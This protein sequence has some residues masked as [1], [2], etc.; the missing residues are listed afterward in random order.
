MKFV[1]IY[2]IQRFDGQPTRHG[3]APKKIF[4]SK[5]IPTGL[6]PRLKYWRDVPSRAEMSKRIG[7][8]FED[9]FKFYPNEEKLN[10]AVNIVQEKWISHYGTSL[11]VT[12][13][14]ESF[15]TLPKSTSAGLPF[16]SGCTKYEARN[17]MMRFARSQ[18]DRV[19]KELQ[20][21]VLPCRLGARCQLRKRGENKPRL[22][23]AYPG[24]LSIIEN[25]YLT[26]IKKVPPP[27]FIGWST[28]WLDGGKSLN[29]LLFGDKWTWQ[30]IAQIDF[31]SFDATVRTELIFHAFKILRS[32]FDLTRTENIM[33]DQLRHYFINTPILFYDK[34]IV[35]NRGIP[36][37][38]AFTQIIGTIV[39]MIACQYASLRSRD[40][41]LRIPFSCWLGDDSFLNFETALCR[42]EFEYDYLEKFKELGLN[43]S[44][45]KTHYTTRFI[46]D[47]EVR[48]KG[49]RPYVKFLGKQIDILLDLTFHN[50]LDKLDAQMAL[51]EKEDLSAY[52]TGVR[53]IG[54]VW[55]YGAHYDIYLRILK[56]YLSLKLKPEFHVQQ[57]LS[58]SEKPE[59]T[60]R[61]QENF[62]SSM[63]YQLNL[64]LDIYDL[65]AFPK[66]WDV[67]NRYFGSKYERLDF[68][69]HKIYG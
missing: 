65:L 13:V 40:Y 38:S 18:W 60:K 37:G 16:K 42:Q 19:S 57:L 21:Q 45:D 2:E 36:S 51:P 58:Y 56:V 59:R 50:D 25:Q 5:Y 68:R 7:K 53:L 26:A 33:L 48:F 12:S 17:K 63:K 69:S 35:K 11:N 28:N 8:Y 30:S 43:V 27:N 67:S 10:E 64:D 39:N 52:E 22:I 6:V 34:I 4:R 14:S 49:V 62:F 66:F 61:Y 15:R 47:F 9:E 32:L 3:I 44:I 55:A 54:L 31:S 41:N 20:L 29:R 1:N 46:D 23:W 24:Y